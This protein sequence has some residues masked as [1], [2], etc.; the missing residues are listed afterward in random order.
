MSADIVKRVPDL[1]EVLG[2]MIFAANR[3]L[4]VREMRNCLIEVAQAEGEY[5]KSFDG[6]KDGDIRNALAELAGELE[7]RHNGFVLSEISGGYR[8]QS[9]ES[10][11]IWL[12]YLLN[13]RKASRLS[14]PSL[15]TLA[16]IACR[17]PIS[18][19]DIE[20]IRGVSIDHVIK[21]LMELQLVRIVGRSELPGRPFLFGT[22]QIFLE[23]FGLKDI[24]SRRVGH[25]DAAGV[26]LQAR[27][28][29]TAE[30]SMDVAI[31]A[32]VER[33]GVPAGTQGEKAE[34][35]AIA[36]GAAATA[37]PETSS[38]TMSEGATGEPGEGAET[39]EP[40]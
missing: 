38:E 18:R 27:H 25:G 8:L 36:E 39:H 22:T 5:T 28:A 13:M 14:Q 9:E 33:G 35:A 4:T 2:A 16:I 6:V 7:S 19:A 26:K 12:K 37:T 1:K 24:G 15:E 23:H 21:S 34:S 10:C 20:G 3:A 29:S 17:Q 31:E 30:A 32:A 40:Q 11:G